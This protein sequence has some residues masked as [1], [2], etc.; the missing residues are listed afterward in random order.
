[1][2]NAKYYN[3]IL[4]SELNKHP[5]KEFTINI[6]AAVRRLGYLNASLRE[7][8]IDFTNLVI[9]ESCRFENVEAPQ[10]GDVTLPPPK[11]KKEK[12]AKPSEPEVH[13]TYQNVPISSL[14]GLD[15]FLMRSVEPPVEKEVIE[16]TIPSPRRTPVMPVR[17][18]K[19]KALRK[20]K[21]LTQDQLA[22]LI[23]DGV[24]QAHISLWER[25][26]TIRRGSAQRIAKVL[27]CEVADLS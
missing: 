27:G 15:T 6:I 24:L 23:G 22:K 4:R 20:A 26:R 1:M 25:G 11:T 16:P 8:F 17:M 3:D 14:M 10:F 18:T 7:V 2:K 21:K 13:L 9:Y 5:D 12:P 19:M